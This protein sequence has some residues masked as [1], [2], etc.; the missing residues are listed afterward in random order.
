MKRNKIISIDEAVQVILDGDTSRDQRIRRYR[1]S[2][3][4][5]GGARA[6][7]PAERLAPRPDPGLCG[8]T[9]RWASTRGLNHMAHAGLVAKVIG[10]HWGLVPGLGRMAIENKIQAY[11]LPQG[12]ITHLFRNIAAHKPGVITSVGLGTFV[13]HAYRGWPAQ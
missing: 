2:R 9:G 12:V 7:L 1:L 3:G 5:G 13:D 11:C 8:R 4:A 10:G 6:A